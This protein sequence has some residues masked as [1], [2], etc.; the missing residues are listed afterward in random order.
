MEQSRVTDFGTEWERMND[1]DSPSGLA[2]ATGASIPSLG[3]ERIEDN[4]KALEFE[5]DAATLAELDALDQTGETSLA[6]APG[7]QWWR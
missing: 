2:L 3:L 5:L 4:I 7:D 6:L 1:N